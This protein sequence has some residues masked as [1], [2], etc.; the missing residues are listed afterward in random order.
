MNFT[1]NVHHRCLV[2]VFE[3]ENPKGLHVALGGT[4]EVRL[5]GLCAGGMI[6]QKQRRRHLN[7]S[8]RTN[9]S[10]VDFLPPH[11]LVIY[12]LC[13]FSLKAILQLLGVCVHAKSLQLCP[14]LYSPMDYSLPG[15][16][17]HGI[18]QA[19]ILEWVAMPSS[20]AFSSP[21]DQTCI[22]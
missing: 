2:W 20:R 11:F 18:L 3:P 17:V 21:R 12:S 1:N 5:Q 4:E 8:N 14:T 6:S 10:P 7:L 16:S 13:Y 9:A 19:R 15:S 22:S